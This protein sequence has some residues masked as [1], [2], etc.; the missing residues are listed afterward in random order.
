V[1]RG[2]ERPCGSPRARF[3][4]SEGVGRADRPDG[5]A[6]HRRG[7]GSRRAQMTGCG[8][9]CRWGKSVPSLRRDVGRLDPSAPY[10]S[11]LGRR[12]QG[13]PRRTDGPSAGVGKVCCVGKARIGAWTLR[14]AGPGAGAA[15][16]WRRSAGARFAARRARRRRRVKFLCWTG[17]V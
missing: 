10:A 8:L 4:C 12:A 1:G 13:V 9:L 6:P 17:S 16:A 7:G 5:G 11:G 3:A 15:G 14:R 2:W